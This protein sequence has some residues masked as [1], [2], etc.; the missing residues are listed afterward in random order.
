[1][2]LHAAVNKI[3][4]LTKIL[5]KYLQSQP[6]LNQKRGNGEVNYQPNDIDNRS[7]DWS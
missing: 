1:V 2:G 5:G 3:T 7:N 4:H 6:G